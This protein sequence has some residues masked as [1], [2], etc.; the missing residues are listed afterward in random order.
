[1][2]SCGQNNQPGGPTHATYGLFP[3]L[4]SLKRAFNDEI[5]NISLGNCPGEGKSPAAWQSNRTPNVTG[6]QIACGTSN[7][8]PSLI[9]TFDKKLMLSDVSGDQAV[10]DLHK[11]WDAYS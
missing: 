6:G 1:M 10:A 4:D 11:W 9:W 7:N 2:V 8:H 5:S 3:D